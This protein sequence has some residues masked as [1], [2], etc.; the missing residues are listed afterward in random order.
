MVVIHS[1]EDYGKLNLNQS[2]FN[3]SQTIELHDFTVEQV[4]DLAKRHQL[5]LN[6]AE[7]QQLMDLIGGHP[8]LVRL[9]FYHLAANQNLTLKQ[10]LDYAATDTGIYNQH[11]Q[12]HLNTLQQCPNLAISFK[13]ILTATQPIQLETNQGYQLSSMGLIKRVGNLSEPRNKL[14]CLY[15]QDRLLIES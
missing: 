9:A 4:Q 15:F 7:V 10:L 2:P 13:K 12:R 14:Y 11:L 8:Y 6:H 1:T 3:I 5:S